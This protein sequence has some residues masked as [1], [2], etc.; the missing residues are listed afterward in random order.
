MT[1]QLIMQTIA[2]RMRALGYAN[3]YRHKLRSV[4]IPTSG[5]L[6]INAWNQWLYFPIEYFNTIFG[7]EI[8]SCIGFLK[9]GPS[10]YCEQQY[11]HHGRVV[12]RNPYPRPVHVTFIQVT[13]YCSPLTIQIQK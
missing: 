4:R 12:I 3:H 6:I 5:Q 10:L 9:A 1:T 2:G 7:V 8:E 13:P 11:E